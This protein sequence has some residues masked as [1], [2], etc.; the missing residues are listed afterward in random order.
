MLK[1]VMELPLWCLLDLLL[2]QQVTCVDSEVTRYTQVQMTDA[3][4]TIKP[5]IL[6]SRPT[7]ILKTIFHCQYR[8]TCY[9]P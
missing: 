7:G 8:Q 6:T 9:E 4:M 1:G 3:E 5:I 2:R